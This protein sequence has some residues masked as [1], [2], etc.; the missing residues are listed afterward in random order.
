MLGTNLLPKFHQSKINKLLST[1]LEISNMVDTS[2]NYRTSESALGV[3][4][5]TIDNQFRVSTKCLHH[6]KILSPSQMRNQFYNSLDSLCVD[7]VDYLFIHTTNFKDFS[8]A[9]FNTLLDFKSKGLAKNIGYS[10]DNL[11]LEQFLK[12]FGNY[13][14]AFMVTQ[15]I[16]DQGN[17]NLIREIK[18][19]YSCQI[20][21]KRS[22]AN[23]FWQTKNM[24]RK[25]LGIPTP[26]RDTY[27][28]RWH[29]LSHDVFLSK[30]Q[31]F[32]E[33]LLYNFLDEHIDFVCIGISNL[34]QIKKI[35][36]TLANPKMIN[37]F[38][39]YHSVWGRQF[40]EA[41]TLI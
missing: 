8:R 10:G 19:K 25:F 5:S 23:G 16:V 17:R 41:Q 20:F 34:N 29:N 18:E 1:G 3:F 33:F 9:H 39:Q 35:K 6:I 11:N 28:F 31:M 22:M 15:N 26:D 24:A 12:T 7:S 40:P 2:P 13:L 32:S 38:S 36:K 30:S 4:R 27:R 37:S 14:D 21:S